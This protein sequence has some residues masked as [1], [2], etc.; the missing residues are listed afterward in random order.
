M[1]LKR[2]L[3]WGEGFITMPTNYG[4]LKE[5]VSCEDS[6]SQGTALYPIHVSMKRLGTE[7]CKKTAIKEKKKKK[8]QNTDS[9]FITKL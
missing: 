3:V 5:A 8:E 4:G 2:E 7:Q 1:V 6:L 9:K